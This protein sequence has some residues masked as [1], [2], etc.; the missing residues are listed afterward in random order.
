MAKPKG[1]GIEA[2]PVQDL[3]WFGY[4]RGFI[5]G[6]RLAPDQMVATGPWQPSITGQLPDWAIREFVTIDDFVDYDEC[7]PGVISYGLTSAGYDI[8]VGHEFAVF[9]NAHCEIVD[10]KAISEKA[11]IRHDLTPV[12]HDFPA[13]GQ[14][15]PTGLVFTCRR[16]GLAR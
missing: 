8:R 1:V 4:Q 2:I 7:P 12:R 11:F 9:T 10:P 15:T 16:C 13:L 5:D 14:E 3:V 6:P